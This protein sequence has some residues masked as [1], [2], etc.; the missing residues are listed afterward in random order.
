MPG[1]GH[2][3]AGGWEYPGGKVE[4]SESAKDS[5]KRE[6]KEELDIDATIGELRHTGM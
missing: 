2:S 1:Q 6:L 4:P 5:I 3:A